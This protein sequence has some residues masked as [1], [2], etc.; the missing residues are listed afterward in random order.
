MH[1]FLCAGVT[2][3]QEG[4]NAGDL[5]EEIHPNQ[6]SGQ[7]KTEHR[8]QKQ[9]QHGEEKAGAVPVFCMMMVVRLH[10]ADRVNTDQPADKSRYHR[11]Q[12][13]KAVHLHVACRLNREICLCPDHHRRL[14]DREQNHRVLAVY[15]AQI[16]N[17]RHKQ[18]LPA[19]H[20]MI[21]QFRFL[22]KAHNRAA[23][24]QPL[25]QQHNGQHH[26]AARSYIDKRAPDTLRFEEGDQHRDEYGPA[27]EK[28]NHTHNHPPSLSQTDG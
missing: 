7:D 28:R 6:I 11:H 3:Q 10:I 2:N 19:E 22:I 24:Q 13:R 4:N 12:H 14:P 17:Q 23:G 1:R 20:Q 27:N 15:D 18:K 25:G 26:N 5:P 21:D 8:T 16:D 9:K